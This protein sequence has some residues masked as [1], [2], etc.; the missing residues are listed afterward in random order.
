ME[1]DRHAK[2]ISKIPEISFWISVTS[3]LI[4]FGRNRI[5]KKGTEK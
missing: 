2:K 3:K 4:E 5:N 1:K